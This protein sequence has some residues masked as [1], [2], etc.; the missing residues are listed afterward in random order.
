[1]NSIFKEIIFQGIKK[2]LRSLHPD[3]QAFNAFMTFIW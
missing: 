3:M 2:D 1:M